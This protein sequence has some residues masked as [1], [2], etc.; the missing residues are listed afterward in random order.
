[1]GDRGFS[2]S[3]IGWIL[4][5]VSFSAGLVGSL[6]AGWLITRWGCKRSLISFGI[7]SAVSIATYFPIAAG[8]S[9][10]LL[11]YGSNILV[12]IA[13]GMAFTATLTVM[14]DYSRLETAGTDYTLQVSMVYFS[15]ILA[16]AFG[17]FIAQALGY[18]TVFA[19]C[20]GLT[21]IGVALVQKGFSDQKIVMA[22]NRLS[23]VPIK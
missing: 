21:L 17:G 11:V 7:F 3:D 6:V 13:A 12:A 20:V 14:M 23:E 19:V 5:I 9:D 8:S 2:L 10:L 16:M 1:M 15:G 18:V 22:A 4:G